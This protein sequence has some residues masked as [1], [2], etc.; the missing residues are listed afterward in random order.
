MRLDITIITSK[1]DQ[2]TI[3]GMMKLAFFRQANMLPIYQARRAKFNL[4][5]NLSPNQDSS[6]EQQQSKLL[7]LKWPSDFR[8]LG[9]LIGE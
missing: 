3:F 9:K 6:P 7:V 2:I 1:R 4:V 8:E 5:H